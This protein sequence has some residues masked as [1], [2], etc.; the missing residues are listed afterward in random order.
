MSTDRML[1]DDN[2]NDNDNESAP[3]WAAPAQV[4]H[5]NRSH[6][7]RCGAATAKPFNKVTKCI[8]KNH[9]PV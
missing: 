7:G 4:G 1:D 6:Q 9:D 8:G 3:V 5:R 2:D